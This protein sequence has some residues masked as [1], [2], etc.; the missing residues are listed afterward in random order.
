MS[1][2]TNPIEPTPQPIPTEGTVSDASSPD[3]DIQLLKSQL[4]QMTETCK[5]T[6]A[7]FSN[8]KRFVEDQ[9]KQAAWFGVSGIMSEILPIVD[10]FERAMTH[11][12]DLDAA[13]KEGIDAIYRQLAGLL[14]KHNVKKIETIGKPFNPL[15]HEVLS[16]GPG[17]LDTIIE[18]FEKGYMIG[19]QVLKPAKVIVGNG[20]APEAAAA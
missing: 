15:F 5:R 20:T 14:E 16:Q 19:E 18:E 6:L 2:E 7:D 8:Y 1:D 17:P 9:R 11:M 3:S 13:H 4:D 10:N 12:T